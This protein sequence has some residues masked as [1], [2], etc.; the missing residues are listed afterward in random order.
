MTAPKKPG[1]KPPYDD[2]MLLRAIEAVEAAPGKPA[3]C[4]RIVTHELNRLFDLHYKPRAGDLEPHIKRVLELREEE[5]TR[6]KIAGLP[7]EVVAMLDASLAERRSWELRNLANAHDILL[8]ATSVPLAEADMEIR[9]MRTAYDAE[10]E[11]RLS[12]AD[13]ADE[14]V[15]LAEQLREELAAEKRTSERLEWDLQ[16]SRR[17]AE[18]GSRQITEELLADVISNALEKRLTGKTINS[19]CDEPSDKKPNNP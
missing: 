15:R 4:Q 5:V 7:S 8:R 13:R 9:R 1:P 16:S 6:A 10:R 3:I 12:E 14:A 2:A 18:K 19:V 17:A 11:N